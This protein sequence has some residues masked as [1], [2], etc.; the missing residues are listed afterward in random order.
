MNLLTANPPTVSGAFEVLTKSLLSLS[1]S[2]WTLILCGVAAGVL[3][4]MWSAKIRTL[5]RE[6]KARQA[7]A[8]RKPRR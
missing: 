3:L 7:R 5:E 4:R 8:H 6:K 2:F 1:P